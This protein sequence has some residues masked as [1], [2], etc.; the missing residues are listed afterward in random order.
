M[1]QDNLVRERDFYRAKL[2]EANAR[3]KTL[4]FEKAELLR[5]DQELS[6]RIADI[7]AV[8]NTSFRPPRT[9]QR[10]VN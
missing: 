2:D 1:D 3:L 8:R 9:P 5:R 10:R 4:E 6:K 7:S